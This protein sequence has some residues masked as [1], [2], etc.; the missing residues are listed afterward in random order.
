VRASMIASFVCCLL[1]TASISVSHALDISLVGADPGPNATGEIPAWEGHK[2]L[3]CPSN[4]TPG[5][6]FPNPFKGEKPLFRIDHT[7]VDEHRDRLSPSQI[8]RLKKHQD[9]YMNIYRTHRNIEYC[10]EF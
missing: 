2:N 6:Y 1:L 5:Q 7:N 9:F 4:F 3:P 8:M 10:L